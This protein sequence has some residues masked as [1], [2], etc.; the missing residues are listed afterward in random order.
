MYLDASGNI[1][2]TISPFSIQCAL[3]PLL[4]HDRNLKHRVLQ[5][6]FTSNLDIANSRALATI[7]TF[8]LPPH[9]QMFKVPVTF[10]LR[11]EDARG[12]I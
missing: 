11:P 2:D 7:T 4:W 8:W 6:S 10:L 1:P 5:R 3:R 9:Q 12:E